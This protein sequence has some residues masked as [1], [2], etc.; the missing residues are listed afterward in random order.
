MTDVPSDA[1][2]SALALIAKDLIRRRRKAEREL[3]VVLDED[4]VGYLPKAFRAAWAQSFRDE[5]VRIDAAL[6]RFLP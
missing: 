6:E 1:D 5:I 4:R 2:P 3:E